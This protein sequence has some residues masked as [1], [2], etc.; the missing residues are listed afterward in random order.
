MKRKL[1]SP[2]TSMGSATV[3]DPGG[4]NSESQDSTISTPVCGS[5]SSNISETILF[6]EQARGRSLTFALDRDKKTY[7]CLLRDGSYNGRADSAGAGKDFSSV[8]VRGSQ[9]TSPR[10]SVVFGCGGAETRVVDDENFVEWNFEPGVSEAGGSSVCLPG[11][12]TNTTQSQCHKHASLISPPV[13]SDFSGG[14]VK[15]STGVQAETVLHLS[16][17]RETEDWMSVTLVPS[18]SAV[19]SPILRVDTISSDRMRSNHGLGRTS[20]CCYVSGNRGGYLYQLSPVL[21]RVSVYKYTDAASQIGIGQSYL[22]AVTSTGIETYT[23]RWGAVALEMLERTEKEMQQENTHPPSNLDICLC[24]HEPFLGAVS[25]SVGMDFLALLSKVEDPSGKEETMWSLYVLNCFSLQE[26]FQDM[27]AF[28][29]KIQVTGPSSYIHL[30]QEAHLLLSTHPMH[31]VINDVSVAACLSTVSRLLGDFYSMPGQEDWWLCQPYYHHAGAPLLELVDFALAE[32]EKQPRQEFGKGLLQ[33]LDFVLC[34]KNDLEVNDPALADKV[35][36]IYAVAAPEKLSQVILLSHLKD[37]TAEKAL[38]HLKTWLSLK[39]SAAQPISAVDKLAMVQLHLSLCEVDLA[40]AELT[41]IPR[42][43]LVSVCASNPSLVHCNLEA[44]TPL[45]QLMR[46]HLAPVLLDILVD[47]LDRCLMS[48]DSLIILLKSQGSADI[49]YNNHI[50]EVLELLLCDER[51]LFLFD[52][53][54]QLLCEIYVVRIRGKGQHQTQ[55]NSVSPQKFS[56]PSGCGHFA[57]RFAW[58]DYLPP[59]YSPHKMVKPCAFM[60]VKHLTGQGLR[61]AS[62]KPV[63]V[64]ARSANKQVCS[65][66]LC[67]ENLLKLQS[68]LCWPRLSPDLASLVLSLIDADTNTSPENASLTSGHS[69]AA[70]GGGGQSVCWDSIQLLC[71]AKLDLAVATET[72]VEKFPGVLA[73]FASCCFHGDFDRYSHLLRCLEAEIKLRGYSHSG[74]T[75]EAYVKAY[76][77]LLAKLAEMFPPAQFVLLLPED[78]NLFFLLPFVCQNLQA[79]HTER[80]KEHIVQKGTQLLTQS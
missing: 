73:N 35:L 19:P 22:Y 44:F 1:T 72:V 71:G 37:F 55:G 45:A 6:S 78:G 41:S 50:K 57:P 54:T 42:A 26:Q 2:A 28:A 46:Q 48:L 5:P 39:A 23:S 65:C 70:A 67:H 40:C 20:M 13:L 58:L 31:T 49:H 32:A 53:A 56:L 4:L 38:R 69:S 24:G 59:F 15:S 63:N 52:A 43:E 18:H 29:E 16:D 17:S 64:V 33:Y 51:R 76:K 10:S 14:K 12:H 75:G 30:L 47:M 11:L 25:L 77:D 60:E 7:E 79:G 68:L 62:S 74:Q 61:A 8:G 9:K 27:I 66:C 34:G 3:G 21:T 80:L 36:N